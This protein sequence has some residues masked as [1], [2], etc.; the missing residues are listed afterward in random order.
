MRLLCFFVA[1]K[2]RCDRDFALSHQTT[3]L[4]IVNSYSLP[5]AR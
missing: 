4:L 5:D 3:A 2:K 1:E